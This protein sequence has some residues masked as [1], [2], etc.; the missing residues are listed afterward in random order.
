MKN[1]G[2]SVSENLTITQQV[3]NQ[4]AIYKSRATKDGYITITYANR[5]GKNV[6]IQKTKTFRNNAGAI[7]TLALDMGLNVEC[8]Y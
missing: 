5:I 4:F 8:A 1:Q 7:K 2:F 6:G 3:K